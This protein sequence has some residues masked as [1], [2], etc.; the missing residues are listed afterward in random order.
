MYLRWDESTQLDV[1][2]PDNLR[3][4]QPAIAIVAAVHT[5][6][7]VIQAKCLQVT[8]NVGRGR[9]INADMLPVCVGLPEAIGGWN[10]EIIIPILVTVTERLTVRANAHIAKVHR[11]RT[12]GTVY[13]GC[14][15][16]GP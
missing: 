1:V 10:R 6:Q 4:N 8:Q 11:T 2:K 9:K 12:L 3:S 16:I 5:N 14:G 13:A 7:D 15:G